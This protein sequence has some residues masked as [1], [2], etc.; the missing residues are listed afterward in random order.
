LA[1]AVGCGAPD[2]E[3]RDSIEEIGSVEQ[4]ISA[5]FPS[6]Y[7][8]GFCLDDPLFAKPLSGS[9]PCAVGGA[10]GI[11]GR[12]HITYRVVGDDPWEGTQSSWK[13]EARRVFGHTLAN[14]SAQSEIRYY[15][16]EY[17]Y[18]VPWTFQ[19]KPANDSSA[20]VT[21]R[22]GSCAGD[23][24]SDKMSSFACVPSNGSHWTLTESLPG[25]YRRV[26]GPWS[27]RLDIDDIAARAGAPGTTA[28]HSMLEHAAHFVLPVVVGMGTQPY[29]PSIAAPNDRWDSPY[30]VRN[31]SYNF[32]NWTDSLLC[33]AGS[34]LMTMNVN[35]FQQQSGSCN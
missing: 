1:F 21:I 3:E 17:G 33:S 25:S 7:T 12:T 11:P 2:D 34:F 5:K 23:Y 9:T 30:S 14:P 19:E 15:L 6:G 8:Y 31:G 28:Y 35:D 24:Q 18:G 29:V 16:S 13:G 4:K 26:N 27:I 32:S 22:A 20:F 10:V